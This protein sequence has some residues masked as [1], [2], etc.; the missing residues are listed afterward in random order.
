MHACMCCAAQQYPSLTHTLTL[1]TDCFAR[2]TTFVEG[3]AERDERRECLINKCVPQSKEGR[4]EARAAA[5]GDFVVDV[6]NNPFLSTIRSRI[7]AAFDAETWQ[8]LERDSVCG[9]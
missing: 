5:S 2:R 7:F 1:V 9:L 3:C 4:E 6:C 8:T